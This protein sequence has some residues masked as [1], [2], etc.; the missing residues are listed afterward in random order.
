[1]ATENKVVVRR[2][3][4]TL[5]WGLSRKYGTHK[6]EKRS[7][8]AKRYGC[9]ESFFQA[10]NYLPT[11]CSSLQPLAKLAIEADS[12]AGGLNAKLGK[13]S[14]DCKSFV[15]GSVETGCG[16]FPNMFKDQYN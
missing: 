10:A 9:H 15:G 1:M 12:I 11:I 16:L 5:K 3:E 4:L 14:A 8:L 6:L 13:L 2:S 7:E